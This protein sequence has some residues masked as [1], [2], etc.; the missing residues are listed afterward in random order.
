MLQ[1]TQNKTNQ[2]PKNHLHID[3]LGVDERFYELKD[4][5][6][7]SGY[8]QSEAYFAVVKNQIRE[9]LDT[10]FLLTKES[11]EKLKRWKTEGEFIAVH[12]R[13]GDYLNFTDFTLPNIN[14]YYKNAIELLQKKLSKPKY[15][16]FSDD[17]SWCREWVVAKE[18]GMEIHESADHSDSVMTEFALMSNASHNI[19]AN[20]T[21]SWWAAW[22]NKNPGKIV[23]L[24]SQWFCSIDTIT[25]GL[26]V[27][28]WELM[29]WDM[30]AR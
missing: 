17:P 29:K 20:S 4:G 15:V 16:V 2:D 1:R 30:T 5:S 21:F 8:P 12:V 3:H 26:F 7:L 24:P 6:Y 11:R 22:L 23:V 9:E 14:D 25:A 27:E 28:G 13:R 19:I 18:N 10:E